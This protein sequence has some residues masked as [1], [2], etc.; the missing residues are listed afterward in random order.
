MET[1]P[2]IGWTCYNNHSE[3]WF[4]KHLSMFSKHFQS[5]IYFTQMH[6]GLS[7]N[8]SPLFLFRLLRSQY[9]LEKFDEQNC[10]RRSILLLICTMYIIKEIGFFGLLLSLKSNFLQEWMQ[11]W[12]NCQL[13]TVCVLVLKYS[14]Q[15]LKKILFS[16]RYQNYENYVWAI[17]RSTLLKCTFFF[18]WQQMFWFESHA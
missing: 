8:M 17:W 9:N 18:E 13:L 7:K 6:K 3:G 14:E 11:F 10:R 2:V 5:P 1:R 12:C 16:F 15:N 4:T